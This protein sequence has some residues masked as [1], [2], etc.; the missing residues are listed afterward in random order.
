[1][2]GGE[3]GRKEKGRHEAGKQASKETRKILMNAVA[4]PG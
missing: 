4:D 3:V 2:E 1:M